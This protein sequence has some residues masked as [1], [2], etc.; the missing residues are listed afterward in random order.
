[1]CFLKILNN[2]KAKG[3]MIS[4]DDFG[5]GYSS[6]SMIQNLP[7]DVIKIDKV[8]IDN[9]DLNTDKNIGRRRRSAHHFPALRGSGFV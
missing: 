5:T 8:F 7:I 2:I 3:F 1:M 9:A 6:L 4:I